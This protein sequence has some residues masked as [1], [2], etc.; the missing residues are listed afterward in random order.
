MIKAV[1]TSGN[2]SVNATSALISQSGPTT[3][4]IILTDNHAPAWLGTLSGGTVNGSDQLEAG[5][6]SGM[7]NEA[8]TE[9]FYP[10]YPT[11]EFYS[12][13]YETMTY[14]FSQTID[15]GDVGA[16]LTV[17]ALVNDAESYQIDYIPHDN[18][19]VYQ[20]FPGF[21]I[22]T[23]SPYEFRLTVPAQFGATNPTVDDII[24]ELDVEDITEF[25]VDVAIANTG[26]RL[27]ITKTYREIVYT[28]LTLQTDGSGAVSLKVDD[29]DATNGPLI[30]AYNS[31]GTAV[32]TTIDAF[33]KGY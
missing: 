9:L 10:P 14:T 20:P 16:K 26:T 6:V 19:G 3:D 7:Y 33:I 2:E 17:S 1:D 30:Y 12:E 32:A 21:V 27:P 5:A 11:V 24:V 4:N 23:G 13:R 31:A 28:A 25:L 15:I 29:K 8:G 22:V 18:P